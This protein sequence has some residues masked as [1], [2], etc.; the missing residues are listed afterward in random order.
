MRA[1]GVHVRAA[2]AVDALLGVAHGAQPGVVGAVQ[3]ADDGDLQ[4]ARVLELVDHNQGELVGVLVGHSAQVA[5]EG[6]EGHEQKI[7][8]VQGAQLALLALE[9]R[10]CAARQLDQLRARLVGKPREALQTRL[11]VGEP[12][13]QVVC[14][15]VIGD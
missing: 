13:V 6:V 7:V 9:D 14:L 8:L 2:E 5:L 11:I 3:V 15:E 10:L 1:V 4:G 12:E